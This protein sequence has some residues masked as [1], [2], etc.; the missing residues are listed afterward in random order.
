M[1]N[2][3]ST[4]YTD[5]LMDT[6]IKMVTES[7]RFEK[8]FE[9]VVN[10][11]DAGEKARFISQYHWYTKKI[12][13]YLNG[14]GLSVANI[15]GQPFDP[16]MAATPINIDEFDKNETLII[17]QMIEPIIMNQVGLVKS[18][19]VTLKRGVL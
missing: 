3:P 18:G 16:G 9:R 19:I 15:E 10:R 8:V 7:W 11:L 4:E 6:I 1:E 2:Y 5:K 17:D 13:E 12:Q 14:I